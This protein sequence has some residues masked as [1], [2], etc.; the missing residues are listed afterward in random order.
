M[1]PSGLSS[2]DNQAWVFWFIGNLFCRKPFAE[3]ILLHVGPLIRVFWKLD[4]L[5]F[6]NQEAKIKKLN[7]ELINQ[8]AKRS[9][10][11]AKGKDCLCHKNTFSLAIC[12]PLLNYCQ[13]SLNY[14]QPLLYLHKYEIISSE[15]PN[16]N[17]DSNQ[18]EVF[19]RYLVF[20]IQKSSLREQN[21]HHHQSWKTF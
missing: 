4:I 11:A 8:E 6:I 5:R 16:R 18:K 7:I 3:F 14:C 12:Q 10:L 9:A 1:R 17:L 19:Q 15:L 2:P 13:P 21:Q 20:S